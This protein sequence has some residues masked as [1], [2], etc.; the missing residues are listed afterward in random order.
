[1]L[2]CAL[3]TPFNHEKRRILAGKYQECD[4]WAGG[5]VKGLAKTR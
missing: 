2:S 3:W 1:M 4:S 5:Y